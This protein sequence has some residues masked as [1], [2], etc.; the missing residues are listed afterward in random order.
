MQQMNNQQ[1]DKANHTLALFLFNW[2]ITPITLIWL[3]LGLFTTLSFL[4]C[5]YNKNNHKWL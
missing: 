1:Q 2:V 5:D 4:T 3:I